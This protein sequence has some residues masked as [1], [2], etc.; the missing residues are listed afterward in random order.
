MYWALAA[1]FSGVC[2]CDLKSRGAK[3][4]IK[5]T[6]SRLVI[7][8]R[9]KILTLTVSVAGAQRPCGRAQD[10]T[11]PPIEAEAALFLFFFLLFLQDGGGS[12]GVV[13][14]QAQQPYALRR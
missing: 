1:D 9:E 2:A 5:H 3:N 11:A 12:D 6:N 14:F 10:K 4:R 7:F 8:I 13:F